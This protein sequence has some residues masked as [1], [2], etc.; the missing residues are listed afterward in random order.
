MEVP[1]R[2]WITWVAVL[3]STAL[4]CYHAIMGDYKQAATFGTAALGM[5]GLGRK[6]DRVLSVIAEI[7]SAVQAGAPEDKPEITPVNRTGLRN[8]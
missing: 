5:L 3:G 4:C 2:G 6:A 8:R 7:G 1:M